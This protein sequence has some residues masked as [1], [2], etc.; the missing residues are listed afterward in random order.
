VLE[1]FEQRGEQPL[2]L[3]GWLDIPRTGRV[4]AETGEGHVL[5]VV[6]APR[7][8]ARWAGRMAESG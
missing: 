5:M 7:Q 8:Q 1:A 4:C 3:A 2:L 6:L